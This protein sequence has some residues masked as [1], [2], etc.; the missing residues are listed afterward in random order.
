MADEA[1]PSHVLAA[2]SVGFRAAYRPASRRAKRQFG[3]TEVALSSPHHRTE[4][5]PCSMRTFWAHGFDPA[6][7]NRGTGLMR[8]ASKNALLYWDYLR[9]WA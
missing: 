8:S 4:G 2:K 7:T 1:D 9:P 3:S 6:C 5:K